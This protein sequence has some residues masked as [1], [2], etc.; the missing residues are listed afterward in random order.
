[1]TR[2]SAPAALFLTV[3]RPVP[4]DDRRIWA[5]FARVRPAE[6]LTVEATGAPV[7]AGKT[8]TSPAPDGATTVAFADRETAVAGTPQAPVS[9][10]AFCVPAAMRPEVGSPPIRVSRTRQ[11]AR[12]RNVVATGGADGC[13]PSRTTSKSPAWI[14]ANAGFRTSLSQRAS[15]VPCTYMSVPL[16][17]TMS[18]YVFIAW[19]MRW[20]GAANPEMSFDALSLRRAPIGGALAFEPAT[21]EAG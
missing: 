2:S 18:P 9:A 19:K 13:H 16:S 21:C 4:S 8:T 17:A 12:T 3:A 20:T 15:Y 7:P 1:M 11:G 14:A 6:K 10:N 5:L